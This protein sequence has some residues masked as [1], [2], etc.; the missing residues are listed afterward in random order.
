M[1]VSQ[2]EI[3]SQ[4]DNEAED[5]G[6]AQ[7]LYQVLR[8]VT[9]KVGSLLGADR[10]TIYLLNDDKTELWS[11]VAENEEGEFLDIQVR[12]GEGNCGSSGSDEESYS[13][14]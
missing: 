9:A 11:L 8:E 4:A 5:E 2:V 13:Y 6:S 14:C 10:A 12:V 7:A 1:L 3:L